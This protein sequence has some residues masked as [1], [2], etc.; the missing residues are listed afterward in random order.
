MP[1][2]DF[3]FRFALAFVLSFLFGLERQRAH[4]PIGFG[5]FVFVATGACGIAFVAMLL[6]PSNPLPLLGSIVTGIGF[7]GAGA[8]IKSGE[9]IYGFTSAALIWIFAVFGMVIGVGYYVVG[10]MIY[11]L[12]WVVT[13]YDIFLEK[14][15][16]GAYQKNLTIRANQLI[17]REEIEKQLIDINRYRFVGTEVDRNNNRLS[18]TFSIEAGKDILEQLD[19]RLIKNDWFESYTID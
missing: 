11:V 13:L 7:L 10:I 5:T 12:V 16:A 9:K 4:K 8:L 14:H 1:W 6:T 17:S 3:F 2:S 19:S 15:G 18:I